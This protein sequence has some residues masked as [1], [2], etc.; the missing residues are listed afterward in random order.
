MSVTRDLLTFG[1]AD[2]ITYENSQLCIGDKEVNLTS[3]SLFFVDAGFR[4]ADMYI[5][6]LS[7]PINK[8]K[9]LVSLNLEAYQALMA[10][11]YADKFNISIEQNPTKVVIGRQYGMRKILKSEFDPS[12]YILHKGFPDFPAC[13]YGHTFKMLGYD[14]LKNEYV[15]LAS[16]ILKEASLEKID[17]KE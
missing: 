3:D 5:F 13:P 11:A 12:R 9:G 10:S 4:V 15:R 6:A 1:Y 8:I 16:S 14:R 7:S 2:N 17:Y